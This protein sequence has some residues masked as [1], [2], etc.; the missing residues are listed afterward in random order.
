MDLLI[1]GGTVF[2]SR[3]VSQFF[4]DRG[5]NVYVMNRGNM[6]QLANVTP[7]I[8]DRHFLGQSLKPYRFDA[9]IDITA[10]NREDVNDLLNGLGAYGEY[11]LISSSAVYP[12]NTPL[13][14]SENSPA[15]F[16]KIWGSYGTGKIEAEQVLLSR[17]PDA[18]II[19]PPYIC[20]PMN[21]IY[22][23]AF[24]FE[25][26]E[27][28]RPFYLP[29]NGGLKLQFFHIGDLCRFIDTLISC[30]PQNHIFNAGYPEPVSASDWATM[31]YKSVG[32]NPIFRYVSKKHPQ[33]S[34]FPFYDYEYL[35][36]VS[37]MLKLMNDL[38][39]LQDSLNS[40]YEY[41]RN[42]RELIVRKPLF[43]Y[44]EENFERN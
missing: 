41:F 24:V 28:N 33:R 25:C 17:F 16:N 42:N 4:A 2:V 3:Y 1:T 38:T 26:A 39:P 5:N 9:V 20:G 12:E 22:R 43:D 18:Y 40:S 21:N 44:I 11:I 27:Q 23:E 35:L 32:K 10:Y 37:E 8:A 15:G 29:E 31:C 36:D 14:F 34:Y 13:P 7:I 19:R 30:K 6:P